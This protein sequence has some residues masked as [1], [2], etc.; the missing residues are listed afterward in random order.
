M[1]EPRILVIGYGNLLRGDD[2]VGQRAA[3]LLAEACAADRVTV[4]ACHQLTPELA[5]AIAGAD[6]L[7]LLDAEAGGEPGQIRCRD[8]MPAAGHSGVLA[9]HMDASSLLAMAQMLYGH[10]PPTTIFTV[11]GASFDLG[12]TLSPAV[13][14]ALPL[15]V[16]A[17]RRACE[18][19]S[20][21][22]VARM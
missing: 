14:A 10:A 6:R 7:I 21:A 22:P 9:H 5:P 19:A 17:V 8:L 2:G 3:Q 20:M 4:I 16:A 11:C 1:A 15:L 18:G 13:E 12:E